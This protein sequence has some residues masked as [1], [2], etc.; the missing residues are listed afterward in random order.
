MIDQ[1]LWERIRRRAGQTFHTISGK[2]CRYL[3]D[4][5]AIVVEGRRGA[6]LTCACLQTAFNELPVV[7]PSAFS[8]QVWGKSYCFA[9]L[10]DSRINLPVA[11]PREGATG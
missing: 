5:D 2:A 11:G 8:D 4:G 10:K 7:G 3:P 1:V 6:R 9:V